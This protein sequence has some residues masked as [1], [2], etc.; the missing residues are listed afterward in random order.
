MVIAENLENVRKQTL[1]IV[2]PTHNITIINTL[3]YVL[4][5]SVFI[6]TY[7]MPF[8]LRY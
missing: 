5:V 8:I 1:I 7:K 4:A 2:S 6:S 3:V